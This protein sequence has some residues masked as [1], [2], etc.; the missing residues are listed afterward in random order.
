MT[1]DDH[2]A[3]A[4]TEG[5]QGKI[6]ATHADVAEYIASDANHKQ[7]VKTLTEEHFRRHTGVRTAYNH[8]KRALLRHFTRASNHADFLGVARHDVSRLAIGRRSFP[9]AFHPSRER[10]VAI[11]QRSAS[12][13]RVVRKRLG[14]W[15][16]RVE[17]ID[18]VNRVHRT[19]ERRVRTKRATGPDL[20]T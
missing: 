17:A 13:F 2:H 14:R 1:E 19:N 4:V 7:V 5:V 11:L 6:N 3:D 15:I 18:I 16:G 12:I 20:L 10:A 8:A 9:A